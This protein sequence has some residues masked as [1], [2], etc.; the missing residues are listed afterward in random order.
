ML[1][2]VKTQYKAPVDRCLIEQ[3]IEQL[4]TKIANVRSLVGN[5]VY[6]L[7]SCFDFLAFQ[8]QRSVL[9]KLDTPIDK[10][11][12]ALSILR[13][14]L[15]ATKGVNDEEIIEDI[16]PNA[17]D[18]IDELEELSSRLNDDDYRKKLVG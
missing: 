10:H 9:T 4:I 15:S 13:V 12:E 17:L 6:N 8:F 3:V 16:I 5:Q 1:A 18:S 11:E 2:K 14:L 7:I